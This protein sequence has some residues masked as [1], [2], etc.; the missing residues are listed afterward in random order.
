MMFAVSDIGLWSIPLAIF[1][2]S[3]RVGTPYLFVSLGE[4]ITEKAGRVNLGL[5][6]TLVMGAMSGFGMSYVTPV[7]RSSGIRP[8]CGVL[9][10]GVSAP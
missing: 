9:A 1:A 6:G 10:A 3:I 4:C 7:G 5:E 2:G 8:G